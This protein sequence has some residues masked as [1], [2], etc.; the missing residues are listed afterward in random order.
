MAEAHTDASSNHA[1]VPTQWNAL[2]KS[3]YLDLS[4]DGHRISYTGPGLTD[5]QAGSILSNHPIPPKCEVFYYEVEIISKGLDGYIG[6]GLCTLDMYLN[7]LPGWMEH[8]WGYHGDDGC[9]FLG[10]GKGCSYG[11]CFTTGDV[12][13]CIV[14]FGTRT[15]S[16]TKNGVWLGDA[17]TD[18][19]ELSVTGMDVF[20][21]VGLRSPGEIVEVNFG[22]RSFVFDIEKHVKG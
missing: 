2:Q 10:S 21:C 18:V 12:V 11:P 8:S 13:G 15:V 3:E 7:R 22:R 16:F 20:P 4:A 19:A 9:V 14:N 17:A 5:A 6:I 1:T